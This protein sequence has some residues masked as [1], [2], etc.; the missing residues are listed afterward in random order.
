VFKAVRRQRE[1]V[2]ESLNET[3]RRFLDYLQQNDKKPAKVQEF[4]TSFNR[5]SEE[6]PDLRDDN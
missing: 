3:Q 1:L 5:F 2:L 6:F 4:I